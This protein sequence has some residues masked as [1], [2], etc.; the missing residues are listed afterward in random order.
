MVD[1]VNIPAGTKVLF[2]VLNAVGDSTE[3]KEVESFGNISQRRSEVNATPLA[4][5]TIRYIGGLKDGQTMDITMFLL[6]DDTSQMALKAAYDANSTIEI[7]VQPPVGFSKQLR[8]AYAL[9]GHDVMLGT[10]GEAAKR[11]VTGRIASDVIFETNER[12]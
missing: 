6:T 3:L 9:L 2:E 12:V 8:F 10:G 11:M 7:T 5:D 4:S 1:R